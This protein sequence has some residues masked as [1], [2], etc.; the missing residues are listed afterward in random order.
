MKG[1]CENTNRKTNVELENK[2]N[3]PIPYFWDNKT[4]TWPKAWDQN[5]LRQKKEILQWER[6]NF[7]NSSQ[8]YD[9]NSYKQNQPEK[10]TAFLLLSSC[11]F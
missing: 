10:K 4:Q 2:C 9:S 5:I 6:S 7:H 11:G 3:S 1:W 8:S